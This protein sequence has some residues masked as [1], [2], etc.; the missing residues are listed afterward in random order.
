MTIPMWLPKLRSKQEFANLF[1]L[2]A[3]TNHKQFTVH[4][5]TC[6]AIIVA[7]AWYRVPGVMK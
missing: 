6:Y 5:S 7:H 1:C 2:P 3:T 4:H